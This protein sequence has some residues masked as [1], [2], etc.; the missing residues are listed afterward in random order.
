MDRKKCDDLR[1]FNTSIDFSDN[2]IFYSASEIRSSTEKAMAPLSCPL[3]KP[4]NLTQG[5]NVMN[6]LFG[7]ITP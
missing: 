4:L 5:D 1:V 3:E 6:N 7:G 2:K